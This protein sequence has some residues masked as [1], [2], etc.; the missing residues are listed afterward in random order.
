[1]QHIKIEVNGSFK[2]EVIEKR[3]GICVRKERYN[4]DLAPQYD[5]C[6]KKK[7][8]VEVEFRGVKSEDF[9]ILIKVEPRL[10]DLS[11]L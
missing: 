8:A 3:N 4:N 11:P 1:M 6:K 9:G 10:Q 5:F 2:G 7:D